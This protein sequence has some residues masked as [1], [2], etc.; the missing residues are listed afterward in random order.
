[1]AKRVLKVATGFHVADGRRVLGIFR[2]TRLEASPPTIGEGAMSEPTTTG[3]DA[4]WLWFELSRASWLTL[5]RVM[6]HDMPDEWQGRM[7]QLLNEWDEKW[8]GSPGVLDWETYVLLKRGGRFIKTPRWLIDY[9]HP[10][11]PKV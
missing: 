3:E 2:R 5:P 1:M 11:I 9:R 4:L 7:A 10:S 6:M 8:R